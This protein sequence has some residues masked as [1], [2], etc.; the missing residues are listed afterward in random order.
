M[1]NVAECCGEVTGLG[2]QPAISIEA[3]QSKVVNGEDL[4]F[5]GF[6]REGGVWRSSFVCEPRKRGGNSTA[7]GPLRMRVFPWLRSP[8]RLEKGRGVD[9]NLR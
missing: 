1:C 9:E 2:D 5:P 3:G 7:P 8:H 6:R 4:A